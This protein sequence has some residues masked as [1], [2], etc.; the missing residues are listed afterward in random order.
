M[1][2]NNAPE[3]K[4]NAFMTKVNALIEKMYADKDKKL[5]KPV[6]A[7][8]ILGGEFVLAG[9]IALIVMLCI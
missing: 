6:V 7:W 8:S 5:V 4:E 9:L 3:K 1:T 2:Q